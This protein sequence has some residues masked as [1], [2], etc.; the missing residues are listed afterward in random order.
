M[1]K[2]IRSRAVSL[3]SSAGPLPRFRTDEKAAEYFD[4]HDT[5]SLAETLP[6]VPGPIVDARRPLKP[7]SLRLPTETIAEAKRVAREK[8]IAYQVLLR[9]WINERLAEERRQAS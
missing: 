4:T 5:A 7:I 9:L 8:G 1:R 2:R 3:A 6:V